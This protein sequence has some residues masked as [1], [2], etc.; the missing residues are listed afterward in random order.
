MKS[1]SEQKLFK[2]L[3]WFFGIY[4]GKLEKNNVKL[5]ILINEMSKIPINWKQRKWLPI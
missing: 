3:N 5:K 1:T 4:K 2:I